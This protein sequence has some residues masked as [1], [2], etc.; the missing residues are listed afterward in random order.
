MNTRLALCLAGALM[1]GAAVVTGCT[2]TY[3]AEGRVVEPVRYHDYTYYPD[4]EVYYY[5][6]AQVFYWRDGDRWEHGRALPGR[7][8]VERERGVVLHEPRANPWER[9]AQIRT[10]YPRRE[11][12]ASERH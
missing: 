9:H 8:H 11:V 1:S 4:E 2:G 12:H 3:V 6:T 7:Y 5:P 10:Q